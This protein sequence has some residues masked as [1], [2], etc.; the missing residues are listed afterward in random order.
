[1]HERDKNTRFFHVRSS[2]RAI[3]NHIDGLL[4]GEGK[5]VMDIK[6]VCNVARSYFVDL[7]NFVC[8]SNI[9]NILCLIPRCIT[10]DMNLDLLKP[11]EDKEVL[12]AFDQMDPRIAPGSRKCSFER[13]RKDI[14]NYC[15]E[16]LNGVGV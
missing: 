5:W 12:R 4:D 10:S 7:F 1:M 8:D 13:I 2:H 9:D 3:K 11:V 6:G 16:L 14:L 15:K